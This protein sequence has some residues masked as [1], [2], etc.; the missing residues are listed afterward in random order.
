MKKSSSIV[1]K[2]TA[3]LDYAYWP[4]LR[5]WSSKEFNVCGHI[6]NFSWQSAEISST[7]I[8]DFHVFT[9]KIIGKLVC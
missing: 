2:W 8:F 6:G 3:Y 9:D 4:I 5:F 7:K 1:A